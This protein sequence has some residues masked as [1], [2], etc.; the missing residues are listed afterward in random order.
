MMM[1]N[2]KIPGRKKSKDEAMQLRDKGGERRESSTA[3]WMPAPLLSCSRG[4]R[5]HFWYLLPPPS[6]EG[7]P[8]SFS[9]S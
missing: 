6:L 8:L 1:M 4:S 3:S 5:A 7:Q 9:L 2:D